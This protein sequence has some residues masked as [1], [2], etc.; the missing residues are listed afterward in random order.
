MDNLDF[1]E[2]VK[3]LAPA[4]ASLIGGENTAAAYALLSAAL[5]N[6]TRAGQDEI[7]GEME[8]IGY[9]GDQA[10]L[11]RISKMDD[12]FLAASS[13]SGA[14]ANGEDPAFQAAL[15]QLFDVL[16]AADDLKANLAPAA[17]VLEAVAS[18]NFNQAHV[19]REARRLLSLSPFKDLS[20]K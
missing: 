14:L 10:A 4:V 11:L 5:F 16:K 2:K 7:L 8:R 6:H 19:I 12:T 1:K 15:D 13:A 9:Y 18:G 3:E 20:G 17:A